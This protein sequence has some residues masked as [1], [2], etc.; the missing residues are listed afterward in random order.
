R[1]VCVLVW[2]CGDKAPSSLRAGSHEIKHGVSEYAYAG[3]HRGRAYKTI[4]SELHGLPMPSHAEIVLEG[5]FLPDETRPEGPFGEFTGYY[6]SPVPGE[7]VV[8][9]PRRHHPHQ[10]I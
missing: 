9:R 7:A 6:A 1:Q 3:G 2:T 5:E 10:P 8:P 4:A